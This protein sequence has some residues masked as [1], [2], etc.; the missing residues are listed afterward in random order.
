MNSDYLRK[1]GAGYL[2]AVQDATNIALN[3]VASDTNS[4]ISLEL[5]SSGTNFIKVETSNDG[6]TDIQ[7]HYP[8]GVIRTNIP[9]TGNSGQYYSPEILKKRGMNISRYAFENAM[10]YKY[11]STAAEFSGYNNNILTVIS[12]ATGETLDTQQA[13]VS[14]AILRKS[15]SGT[16]D[17]VLF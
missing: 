4:R 2:N 8:T 5:T 6:T 15:T 1:I 12:N 13:R 9:F 11:P 17:V 16:T 14:L 7:Y 10:G 3:D